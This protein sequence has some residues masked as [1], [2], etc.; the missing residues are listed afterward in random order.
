MLFYFMLM[1]DLG[2]LIRGK[3]AQKGNVPKVTLLGEEEK[4]IRAHIQI[5][6]VYFQSPH[7]ELLRCVAF[8]SGNP[9]VTS[10]DLGQPATALFF[11]A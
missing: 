3:E 8:S 2:V 10:E 6:C 9:K 4:K 1:P 11:A 7:S 5:T